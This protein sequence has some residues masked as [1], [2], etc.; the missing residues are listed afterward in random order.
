MDFREN[1]TRIRLERHMTQM[2]LAML[3]GV[4]LEAVV[5]WEN[6]D[7]E[8]PLKDL[9]AISDALQVSV[10]YLV[11]KNTMPVEPEAA[12]QRA[13]ESTEE[14]MLCPC[15][16]REIKGSMC[17]SCEF[18]ASGYQ[19]KGPKY[20]I[21]SLGVY[22]A[23]NNDTKLQLMKYCGITDEEQLD[24]LLD[25]SKR[26]I[27]KRGLSDVAAHWIASRINPELLSLRIVEDLGEPE[28][29]LL[30][31]PEVMEK[32][33]YIFKKNDSI[34]VGGIILIVVLTI[35]ALSIF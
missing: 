8:P 10:D 13:E 7:S 26:Q 3:L 14:A 18:P 29:E 2:D 23:N 16:G 25:S 21:T 28:E 4:E 30:Q 27:L 33:A 15:C 35:I 6:G 32:P 9:V 20:A 31:K 12:A 11:G 34:G 22:S 1:L 17:L 19:S 24:N 5:Q